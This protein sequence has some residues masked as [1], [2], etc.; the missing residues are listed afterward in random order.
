MLLLQ[1]DARTR[2]TRHSLSM[3]YVQVKLCE[4][5]SVHTTKQSAGEAKEHEH[6][7]KC[8]TLAVY[9]NAEQMPGETKELKGMETDKKGYFMTVNK[10]KTMLT[11]SHLW[12]VIYRPENSHLFIYSYIIFI[13][14]NFLFFE[15]FGLDFSCRRQHIKYF[16]KLLIGSAKYNKT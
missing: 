8:S 14:Y 5:V 3:D 2:R 9:P 15:F 1:Y 11:M 4:D 6:F 16:F 13:T 10:P 7:H 12:C